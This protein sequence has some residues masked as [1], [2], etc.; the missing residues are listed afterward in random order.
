MFTKDHVAALVDSLSALNLDPPVEV[1]E[2]HSFGL[3]VD[4]FDPVSGQII[5]AA[6][7]QRADIGQSE[8]F[9]TAAQVAQA[10]TGARMTRLHQVRA[11]GF[12]SLEAAAEHDKRAAEAAALAAK[13]ADERAKLD[14]DHAEAAA[15][16]AQAAQPKSAEP[17]ETDEA[18][19]AREDQEARDHVTAEQSLAAASPKPKPTARPSV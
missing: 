16:A 14:A 17:A 10:V 6:R 9:L 2:A 8:I 11:A 4:I 7:P 5:T 3:G 18:K 19:K 15:A 13:Q 12:P 1:A